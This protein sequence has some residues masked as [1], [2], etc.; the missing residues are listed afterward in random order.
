MADVN[1]LLLQVVDPILYLEKATNETECYSHII[2]HVVKCAHTQQHSRAQQNLI[3]SSL[4][5][6][7]QAIVTIL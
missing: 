5:A 6:Q 2:I 1:L 4:M 3:S 7:C